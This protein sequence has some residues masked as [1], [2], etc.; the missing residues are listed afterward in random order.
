M[1]GGM[2]MGYDEKYFAKSANKK[3]MIIWLTLAVVLT[4]S[5]LIEIFKGLRTVEYYLTFLVFCWLPFLIGL[6]VVKIKG[7]HTPIYKDVIAFG[8]G[9]FYGFV[10]MTTDTMLAVM[11]ILPLT[12]ML[13]LFKN[14]NFMIRCCVTNVLLLIIY[15][16]KNYMA[17]LNSPSDITNYEI[18]LAA[19]VLCY[20]GYILSINHLNQSD[21]A[22]V[23]SIK[24]NLQKVVSTIEQV[25]VA[26][27]EVVDG[28]TVVRELSDENKDGAEFVVQGMEE[29]AENNEELSQKI[30]SSMEMTEN[31][32]SQVVDVAELTKR[33]VSII[34]ESIS[35]ATTSSERLSDVV[36]ST[37]VM[38]NLSSE[39]ENILSE[40][41]NEFNMVK[42]ETGTIESITSQTNLLAL[43]ASIEAA[44]AGE[45]GKGF[46]VVAEEIRSLSMG[47]QTSSNSIMSALQ[48]LETTSDRMTEAITNILKLIYETL[49]KMKMVD[50][51][52][53]TITEESMQLGQEIQVVDEAIK[54]VEVS[55]KN[56]VDNMKQVTDIMTTVTQSVQK[57][58]STTKTMLSKYAETSNNVGKIET[59]VGKLVEE[60][61]AG[62][63][64]SL[65]DIRKGMNISIKNMQGTAANNEIMTEVAE[66]MEDG[67]LIKISD[68]TEKFFGNKAI[69][70]QYEVKITVD[71]ALY[72]WSDV[73][74]KQVKQ[75]GDI[76]YKVIITDKPKVLNRRK[77]PRLA[78]SNPCKI[79]LSEEDK[80]FD[81]RVVN[82]SAGGFAFL[83]SERDFA[84]AKG[85][86]VEIIIQDFD[87]LKGAGLKGTIIRSTEDDGKYI[88]GCRMNKDNM[89]ICK[90]VKKKLMH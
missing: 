2:N 41:R 65:E 68:A 14:R 58:E 76:Y 9:F 31:I 82:I 60:L 50:A 7:W 84:N 40:F 66:T 69:R 67:L 34:N 37:N 85:K 23:D 30:D 63:F 35:H 16:V 45:A 52:V 38:A 51:S 12:S 19:T 90:Y 39:I 88:V 43:N 87:L 78:M 47:T 28:V 8:Y 33:I 4:G 1:H 46:V 55:N 62:G 21:G 72:I 54:K 25:K 81:A 17:G 36:E 74:V 26:S 64:M 89:E 48:N 11:F 70:N 15:I 73:S 22:M 75:N 42:K 53:E 18:Q 71:N 59:V 27:N 3:A 32:N 57:S 6:V 86:S 10:L 61:G 79:V 20:V 77:Y 24:D 29:L 80:T 83:C 49:D 44:R 13:I 5:Y 56:M